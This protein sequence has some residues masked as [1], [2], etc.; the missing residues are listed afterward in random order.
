M[1]TFWQGN[2][3]RS[4]Q[5]QSGLQ[6]ISQSV[7][8]PEKPSPHTAKKEDQETEAQEKVR[9]GTEKHPPGHEIFM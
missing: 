3:A 4:P 5:Q 6:Q 7:P 8:P 9:K 2:W 1:A